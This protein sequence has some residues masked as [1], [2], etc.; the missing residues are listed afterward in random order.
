MIAPPASVVSRSFELISK[1]SSGGLVSATYRFT[2][3]VSAYSSTMAAVELAFVNQ[4]ESAINSIKLASKKLTGRQ[5]FQLQ[6]C[7]E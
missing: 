4:S 2:R 6:I 5:L 1:S 7:I 3:N